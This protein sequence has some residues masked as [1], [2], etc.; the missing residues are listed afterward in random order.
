MNNFWI[1]KSSAVLVASVFGA[2]L[3]TPVLGQT[4]ATT[5]QPA[6]TNAASSAS[7]VNDP[8]M[9][10]RQMRASQLMGKD[11]RNAQG[12]DL[13]DIKGVAI[14]VN[15]GRVH[16]VVLS[17]GG[18]LGL[19]DKLFAYPARAFKPSM[20]RD[21][22]VLTVAKEKLKNAP[23]FEASS[24]PDWNTPTYR[25]QVDSYFG[26]T[27]AVPA[28]SNVRLVR[29][30]ELLGKDVNGPDG[31]DLGEIREVVIDMSNGDVRY[32]VLEFD[33]S[34]SLKDKLFA[35]PMKAFKS[36]ASWKDDLVLNVNKD[37]LNN[38]PG[39]NK[40]AWPNVNDPK[41]I[42]DIDRYLV[43]TAVI[44]LPS[45]TNDALFRKLD[46]NNAEC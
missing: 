26:P 1:R 27:T 12:E 5:K 10:A 37:T 42:V 11:V 44:P 15:N 38:T 19:G 13:G 30:S 16:F 24:Y 17:F 21:E 8:K 40:N 36:G 23:G 22:L 7:T 46:K 18:F 33:Q 31:R 45:T 35:F 29:A 39:F 28:Q 43:A 32:A 41:W 25:G 9:A 2:A 20:D 6:T 34:W 3:A 4:T 14:D